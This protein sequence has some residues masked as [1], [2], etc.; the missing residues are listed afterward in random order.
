MEKKITSSFN[1]QLSRMYSLAIVNIVLS[2]IG[3]ILNFYHFN[4]NKILYVSIFVNAISLIFFYPWRM[5]GCLN[6]RAA[7]V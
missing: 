3:L 2:I 1:T 4:H 6:K 5:S 7:N